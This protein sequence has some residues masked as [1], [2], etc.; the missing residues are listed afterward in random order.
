VEG[1]PYVLRAL[2]ARLHGD[3]SPFAEDSPEKT[4]LAAAFLD[5]NCAGAHGLSEKDKAELKKI[6]AP[7]A[8]QAPKP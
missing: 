5:E 8:A 6:A 3:V 4:K 2:L 1:A 7:A